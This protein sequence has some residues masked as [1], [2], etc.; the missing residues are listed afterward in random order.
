MRRQSAGASSYT[1]GT[2]A[3][4]R[5]TEKNGL[6]QF[7]RSSKR[8]PGLLKILALRMLAAFAL[9]LLPGMSQSVQAQTTTA[10]IFPDL[11]AVVLRESEMP[12]YSADPARTLAQDRPDGSVTYDAVYTR[13][14]G[15]TGPTEVRLAAARTA[16]GKAS[17]QA[18]SS[19]RDALVGAGWTPRAVPLLGDEALGFETTGAPAGG[20]SNAGY[21]YIFRFGRHLIGAVLTGPASSTTFDHALGYAVQMSARL[22]AMLALA[23]VPDP[24]PSPAGTVAMT[25]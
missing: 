17:A 23:P 12:G 10:T 11:R 24:D 22:D 20:T 2:V 5:F 3:A 25:Q 7:R 19:T 6:T 14:A 18:L 15:G 1:A 16:S 8:Q 21:G 4:R 9:V 13:P